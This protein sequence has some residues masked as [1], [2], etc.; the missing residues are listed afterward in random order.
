[1]MMATRPVESVPGLLN[2]RGFVTLAF[3]CIV[4][5]NIGVKRAEI[6]QGAFG[7]CEWGE[8]VKSRQDH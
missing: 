4:A 2:T 5:E 6:H 1:M 8:E 7:G 3:P